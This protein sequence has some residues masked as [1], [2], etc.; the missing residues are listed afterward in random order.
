MGETSEAPAARLPVALSLPLL[1]GAAV[2]VTAGVYGRTH[3][4]TGENIVDLFFS[5]TATMKAW[6]ATL[7]VALGVFQLASALKLYG[8]LLPQRSAPSWLGDAHR[9]SGTVAFLATLPVAYHCLWSFGYQTGDTRVW[10]HSLAGCVF[11]GAL[12]T[13]VF[14]VRNHRLPGW[15]LPAAGGLVFTVLV[16]AWATSALWLFTEVG[17]D[18]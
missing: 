6:L 12:T 9:L 4:P 3:D 18:L 11:Y 14:V 15:A 13:K 16:V 17:V 1:A 7:A 5:S 10:V 8:R 2:A